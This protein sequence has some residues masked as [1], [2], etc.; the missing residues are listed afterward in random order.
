MASNFY[1]AVDKPKYILG[2]SLDIEF[3][4]VGLFAVVVL[5]MSYARINKRDRQGTEG[6]SLA[7]MSDIGDKAPTFR[8][9]Y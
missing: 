5:R 6:L 1:R 8:Y 7:T 4:S 9:M 2:H 3:V